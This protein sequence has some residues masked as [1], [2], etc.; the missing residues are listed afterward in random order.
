MRPINK[1]GIT[2]RD[3]VAMSTLIEDLGKGIK[4]GVSFIVEKT[5]ELTR[6]GK[7]NVEILNLK[8]EMEKRQLL[9][10]KKVFELIQ[11]KQGD[12]IREDAGVAA[13]VGEI[14]SLSSQLQKK[15]E[16]LQAFQNK[17]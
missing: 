4:D 8:R 17:K 6:I 2:I 5:D 16:E 10:G 7:Y 15:N 12:R 3:D 1:A 14:E 13:L 11:E 9:L